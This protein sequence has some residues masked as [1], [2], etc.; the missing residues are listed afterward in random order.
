M[1]EESTTVLSRPNIKPS[2]VPKVFSA[3]RHR[4]FQL[5]FGGQLVSNAGTW[6][7]VIAQ[8]WLVYELTHSEFALGVVS[9]ASA[10]PVLIVSLWGGMIVDRFPKRTLLVITQASAMCLAFILAGLTFTGL[11]REW[12][13]ILLAALLGVVN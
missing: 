7:Q 6:M 4:N 11:V 8:G 9:F 2:R 1:S 10:L 13:I 5:Y 12:H 3:M